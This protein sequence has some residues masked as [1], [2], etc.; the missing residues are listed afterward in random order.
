MNGLSLLLVLT[1][2]GTTAGV[3]QGPNGVPTYTI[4]IETLLL[5]ELRNGEEIS[6]DVAPKDRQVRHFRILPWTTAARN[7][8]QSRTLSDSPAQVDYE[9]VARN[10]GEIEMWVQISPERL[11]TL[12]QGKPI[13]GDIPSEVPLVHRFRIFVGVNQLPRQ[14]APTSQPDTAAPSLIS[15]N[16]QYGFGQAPRTATDPDSRYGSNAQRSSN[17]PG[18]SLGGARIFPNPVNSADRTALRNQPDQ[19]TFEPPPGD[20]YSTTQGTVAQPLAAQSSAPP[21]AVDPRLNSS[22]GIRYDNSYTQQPQYVDRTVNSGFPNAG[23][24]SGFAGQD[25]SIGFAQRPPIQSPTYTNPQI[26]TPIVANTQAP[27]SQAPVISAPPVVAT[28][29]ASTQPVAAA[30]PQGTVLVFAAET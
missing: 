2:V 13:D 12:A 21:Y 16:G 11:E 26:Q 8:S 14:V 1:A 25:S 10:N 3:E 6:S 24:G 23:Q 22:S 15:A 18:T 9:A 4:R 28:T 19:S 30:A 29:A 7:S 17:Q 20:R 27:S 5:N